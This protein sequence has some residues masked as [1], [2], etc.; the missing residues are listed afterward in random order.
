MPWQKCQGKKSVKVTTCTYEYTHSLIHSNAYKREHRKRRHDGK[1][2]I[3]HSLLKVLVSHQIETRLSIR[4]TMHWYNKKDRSQWVRDAD[5]AR[6]RKR[7]TLRD[8]E[9]AY[10]IQWEWWW[11]H[12]FTRPVAAKNKQMTTNISFISVPRL[13]VFW[14]QRLPFE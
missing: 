5:S 12:A 11:T 6:K 2:E 13:N 7:K 10:Y 3:N 14:W 8:T 1:G 4:L 9:K